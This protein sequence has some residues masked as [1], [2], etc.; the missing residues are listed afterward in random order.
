MVGMK[1]TISRYRDGNGVLSTLNG[2]STKLY[3]LLE[4]RGQ[5]EDS[6]F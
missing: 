3:A 5:V 6:N 2:I 4:V 1:A